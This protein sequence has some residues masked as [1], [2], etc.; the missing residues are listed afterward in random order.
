M[1][2]APQTISS[3]SSAYDVIPGVGGV[4]YRL[5]WRKLGWRRW[6]LLGRALLGLVWAI[7]IEATGFHN[8]F[9][10]FHAIAAVVAVWSILPLMLPSR[11]EISV[12]PRRVTWREV[13][14]MKRQEESVGREQI[15]RLRVDAVENYRSAAKKWMWVHAGDALLVAELASGEEAP[16]VLGYPH[17]VVM[18]VAEVLRRALGQESGGAPVN[19]PGRAAELV[20]LSG[21]PLA[22]RDVLHPPLNCDVIMHETGAL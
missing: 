13:G 17:A 10:G 1:S 3:A 19:T 5:G 8:W 18:Q 21:V 12:D 20:D 14:W 9:W 22:A 2:A 4:T 16:L 11:G 6:T 7:G 15:V